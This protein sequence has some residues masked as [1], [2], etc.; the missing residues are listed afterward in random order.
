MS[1][2]LN[3]F[4]IP[5]AVVIKG[6]LYTVTVFDSFLDYYK[7]TNSADSLGLCDRQKREIYMHKEG[8]K[9]YNDPE[10]ELYLTYLHEIGHAI[11]TEVSLNLCLE[12][13]IEELVVDNMSR[14]LHA[15]I[16]NQRNL[17]VDEEPKTKPKRRKKK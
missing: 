5:S 2:K 14:E 10:Q 17:S 12:S 7:K 13:D 6:Q 15:V 8:H 16:A 4:I 3:R 1:K 11:I 9:D